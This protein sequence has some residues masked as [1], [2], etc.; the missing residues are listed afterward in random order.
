MEANYVMQ[1]Q[2]F[3]ALDDESDDELG[4]E[5]LLETPLDKVEP[6][7]LFRDALMSMFTPVIITPFYFYHPPVP[8]PAIL[9]R[10]LLP[11][12]PI[13]PPPGT[14]PPCPTPSEHST[15][16]SLP[17]PNQPTNQIKFQ[18]RN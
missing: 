7:S 4:E 14:T 17:K 15:Q 16:P 12:F 5:S 10:P 18:N 8:S 9:T 13:Y 6:Y 3:G 11:T 1:A 2:K